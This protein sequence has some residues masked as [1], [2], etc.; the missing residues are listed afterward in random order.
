MYIESPDKPN[1][2]TS[3]E[4]PYAQLQDS[5]EKIHIENPH[6]VDLDRLAY[7][8][9]IA[10]KHGQSFF[11]EWKRRFLEE[12]KIDPMHPQAQQAAIYWEGYRDC[13][14]SAYKQAVAH[15]QRILSSTS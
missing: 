1:P 9:F 7:E 14:R 12:S 13:M 6:A 10:N 3:I 2:F 4:D 5:I 8:T 11:N 15:R